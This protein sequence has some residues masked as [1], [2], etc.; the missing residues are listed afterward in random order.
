MKKTVLTL[1]V[2]LAS[3]TLANAQF[4]AGGFDGPSANSVAMTT[5]KDA[6][7]QRDDTMVT[8]QGNIVNSLGDEKYTFKDSTGEMVI[9]IDDED[10]HGVKVVPE[11]V[12]EIYGEVDRDYNKPTKIDVKSLKLK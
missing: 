10:W 2:L 3:T 12:V 9:E 11:N 5:V 7:N 6:Q 8:L 4:V 1:G